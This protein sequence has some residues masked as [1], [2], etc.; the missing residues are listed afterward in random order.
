MLLQHGLR[1]G[2]P[3][4]LARDLQ[5]KLAE[6]QVGPN[7]EVHSQT[8]RALTANVCT[9]QHGAGWTAHT[10]NAK[11]DCKLMAGIV[12]FMHIVGSHDQTPMHASAKPG[13]QQG[14]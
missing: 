5:Q 10:V 9:V 2:D 7:E 1:P 4:A 8:Q 3:A 13:V 6:L 12:L 14:H 11:H